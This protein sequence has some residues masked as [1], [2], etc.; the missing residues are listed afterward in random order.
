M[1]LGLA[2]YLGAICL[3]RPYEDAATRV[4]ETRNVLAIYRAVL[5]LGV[6]KKILARHL[7]IQCSNKTRSKPSIW[8]DRVWSVC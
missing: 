8:L 5:L 3:E 2:H 7:V 4:T 1:A 6:K